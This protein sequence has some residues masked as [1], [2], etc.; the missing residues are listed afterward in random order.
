[1]DA[2][3]CCC[4]GREAELVRGIGEGG[5]RGE[6]DEACGGRGEYGGRIQDESAC[7]GGG[8]RAGEGVEDS[9]WVLTR[10]ASMSRRVPSESMSSERPAPTILADLARASEGEELWGSQLAQD[11]GRR[12]TRSEE[13]KGWAVSNP[14]PTVRH[15]LDPSESSSLLCTAYCRGAVNSKLVLDVCGW[16]PAQE[17]EQ[18]QEQGWGQLR[19]AE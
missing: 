13:Q 3:I 19:A 5:R 16:P 9:A 11:K 18:E 17:E 10:S 4:A 6:L 7:G 2:A 12:H 15:G 8:G 1:M 14:L